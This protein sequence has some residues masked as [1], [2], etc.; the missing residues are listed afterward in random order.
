MIQQLQAWHLPWLQLQ[1]LTQGLEDGQLFHRQLNPSSACHQNE[2]LMASSD[3]TLLSDHWRRVNDDS[4][5]HAGLK[6]G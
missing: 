2:G 3:Q 1:T 6:S 5:V 4:G